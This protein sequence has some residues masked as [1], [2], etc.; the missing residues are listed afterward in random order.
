MSD[1]VEMSAAEFNDYVAHTMP[2]RAWQQQ[3][4]ASA[5]LLGWRHYHTY[6][7]R[8]SEFGFPDSVL[9]RGT[10]LVFAELK[11]QRGKPTAAQQTWL[12]ELAGV[13]SVECYLWRPADR[14]RVLEILS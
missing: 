1:L 4:A 14:Q 5:R 3:L 8:R 6:D 7:S 9:L 2:E 13:E 12:A 11:R 10:R